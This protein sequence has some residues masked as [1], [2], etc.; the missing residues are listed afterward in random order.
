MGT[1]LYVGNLSFKTSPETVRAAFAATGNVMDVVL[2]T[3]RETGQVRGFA[4]VV[5]G[6]DEEEA[7]AI[8]QLNGLMLDGRSLKVSEA[9]EVLRGAEEQAVVEVVEA[10]ET[11]IETL[12]P[13]R[14]LK[15]ERRKSR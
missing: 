15:S 11:V 4:F 7:R 13:G 12:E 8:A 5:M 1:L 9:Q 14:R 6:S 10:E 2:A 3:D